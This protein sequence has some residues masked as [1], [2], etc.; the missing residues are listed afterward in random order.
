VVQYEQLV[1]VWEPFSK[2]RELRY[3]RGRSVQF[4]GSIKGTLQEI[5]G[6][7]G[8]T[9]IIT[10]GANKLLNTTKNHNYFNSKLLLL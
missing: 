3:F 1:V 5:Q 10:V 2:L 7:K 9:E 8:F 6:I 4:N